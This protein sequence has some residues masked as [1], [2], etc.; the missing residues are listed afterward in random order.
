MKYQLSKLKSL[1]ELNYMCQEMQHPHTDLG[2]SVIIVKWN[3]QDICHECFL[4]IY[5]PLN[6][7]RLLV[8]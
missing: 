2:D 3:L 4:F 1:N 6:F 5:Q 7:F 8:Q